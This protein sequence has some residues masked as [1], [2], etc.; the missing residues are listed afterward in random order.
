MKQ[1]F[2]FLS[3]MLCAILMTTAFTAC[4]DDDDEDNASL[5]GTWEYQETHD[6]GT[7]WVYQ[8]VLNEDGTFTNSYW[9]TDKPDRKTTYE[10]TYVVD[11]KRLTIKYDYGDVEPMAY[12]IKGNKLTIYV[13]DDPEDYSIYY[14]K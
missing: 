8:L 9:N 13:Y 10:G 7:V 4:S 3:M 12:S 6:D 5:I 11:G 14:R 2:R 1:T